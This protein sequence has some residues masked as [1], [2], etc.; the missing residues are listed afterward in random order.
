MCPKRTPPTGRATKPTAK[1]ANASRV[2]TTSSPTGKNSRGK[3]RPAAV[4]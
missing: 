3:T 2:P 4:A 1:V